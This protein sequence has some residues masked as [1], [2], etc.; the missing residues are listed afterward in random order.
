MRA[1]ISSATTTDG[2]QLRCAF[3]SDGG[4]ADASLAEHT[5]LAVPEADRDGTVRFKFEH[6]SA[7]TGYR[8]TIARVADGAV[9]ARGAFTTWSSETPRTRIAFGSCADIDDSTALV[10]RQIA[11]QSPDALVLLGDTPYIDSTELSAQ[12]ARHRA[13]ASVDSFEALTATIPTI[14]T[15]DDHDFGRNDTDGRLLAANRA[16][17]PFSSTDRLNTR[18]KASMACSHRFGLAPSKCFC[19]TRVGSPKPSR[20]A[21][22]QPSQRCSAKCSGNGL[23]KHCARALRQSRSSPAA[24]FGTVECVHLNLTTGARIRMNSCDFSV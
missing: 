8:Y 10:W 22:I 6:L 2:A 1:G 18:G 7:G 14:A 21:M 12:R 3:E 9:L 24:W 13:F 11:R 16:A 5:V 20:L 17:V 23:R 19:S 15:W 4:E